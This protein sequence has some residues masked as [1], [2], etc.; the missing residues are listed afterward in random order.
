[1]NWQEKGNLEIIY[2]IGSTL[3][4]RRI[5]YKLSQ[6][7]LAKI[8]GISIP[9]LNRIENGKGNMKI[10]SLISLFRVLG[11]L[12]GFNDLFKKVNMLNELSA[13]KNRMGEKKERVRKSTTNKSSTEGWTWGDEKTKA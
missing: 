1:M 4:D 10:E 11:M 12:D 3:K 9:S 5:K 8:S 13:N 2:D 6:Q 7:E